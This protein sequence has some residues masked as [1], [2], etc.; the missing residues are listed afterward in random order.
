MLLPEF[1]A[2]ADAFILDEY[3]AILVP[4]EFF[5]SRLVQFFEQ[6]LLLLDLGKQINQLDLGVVSTG[7][8][9]LHEGGHILAPL[10][11][12]IG[13]FQRSSQR[14]YQETENQNKFSHQ[15]KNRFAERID[16]IK[17]NP[18]I[19]VTIEVPP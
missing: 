14:R 6:V 4:V 11:I 18:I 15:T 3:A 1:D 2:A 19:R 5:F 10:V 13:D 9:A 7:C 8:H 17:P 12:S 16:M